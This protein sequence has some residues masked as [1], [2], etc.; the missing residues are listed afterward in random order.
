MHGDIVYVELAL[1]DVEKTLVFYRELFG[2][3][4][5]QSHLS[6]QTY[7]MFETP[8]KRLLGAFDEHVPP[9]EAG[10]RMYLQCDDIEETITHIRESHPAAQVLKG[11]TFISEEY[12]SYALVKDPSGNLVGL[13][14]D[15][16]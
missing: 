14:E 9:S 12:G 11:K 10:A 5:V 8:G 7:Y 6:V 15:S 2:W 4:I 13:Q 1:R 3:K 16:G